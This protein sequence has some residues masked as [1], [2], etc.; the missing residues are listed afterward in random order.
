[1]YP[2]RCNG[3]RSPILLEGPPIVTSLKG[4]SVEPAAYCRVIFVFEPRRDDRARHGAEIA[5]HHICALG[6]RRQ[7][8]AAVDAEATSLRHLR[9]DRSELTFGCRKWGRARGGAPPGALSVVC[10]ISVVFFTPLGAIQ[11]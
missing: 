2:P 9:H 3:C 6:Q 11:L 8:E 10:D 7:K 5:R 4:D 1:M